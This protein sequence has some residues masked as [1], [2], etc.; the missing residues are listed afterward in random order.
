MG[1]Y[2]DSKTP[3][4]RIDH[5]CAECGGTILKGELYLAYKPGL[6]QTVKVH[7]SCAS[8]HPRKYNCAVLCEMTDAGAIPRHP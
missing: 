5:Q 1:T 7:L 2:D 3:R 6:F 8:R 4:A